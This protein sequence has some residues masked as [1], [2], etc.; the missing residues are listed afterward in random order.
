MA[1][2]IRRGRNVTDAAFLA[3]S[4]IEATDALKK[5]PGQ[6]THPRST[7]L[8]PQFR[9]LWLGGGVSGDGMPPNRPYATQV[10]LLLFRHKL[11]L[12]NAAI[13]S[14]RRTYFSHPVVTSVDSGS[15]WLAT[16]SP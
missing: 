4:Q 9:L 8:L 14:V 3:H 2:I 6:S 7:K 1:K 16:P 15:V 12:G 13:Y 11:H 10:G 5:D